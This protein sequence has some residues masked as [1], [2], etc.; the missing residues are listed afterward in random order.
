MSRLVPNINASKTKK[1]TNNNQN[2]LLIWLN[3]F[4]HARNSSAILIYERKE[5]KNEG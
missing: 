5:K 2:Q 3:Q 1:H 4:G